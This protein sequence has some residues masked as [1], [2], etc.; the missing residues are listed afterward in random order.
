MVLLGEVVGNNMSFA[1]SFPRIVSLHSY[2]LV[3]PYLNNILCMCA[4]HRKLI[5]ASC[6]TSPKRQQILLQGRHLSRFLD[7][8]LLGRSPQKGIQEVPTCE[9]RSFGMNR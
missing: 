2:W 5:R 8:S 9:E 4:V 6:S 7:G 1:V 3:V